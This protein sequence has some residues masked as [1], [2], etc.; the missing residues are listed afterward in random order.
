[1]PQPPEEGP[2]VPQPRPKCVFFVRFI[3]LVLLAGLCLC[4]R[5]PSLKPH[6]SMTEAHLPRS[7]CA[8][9][10]TDPA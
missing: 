1:M 9:A 8:A 6:W 4:C 3:S 7:L 10:L 2:D 5:K